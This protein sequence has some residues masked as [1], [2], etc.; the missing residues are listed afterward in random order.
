M[1]INLEKSTLE[2]KEVSF[3]GFT[4]NA[5]GISPDSALV[6]RIRTVAA[7]KDRGELESF[8]GLT[9]FFG[10]FIPN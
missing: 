9:N 3:L 10:R 5:K 4:T 8:L 6:D 2:A 7:R 1:S